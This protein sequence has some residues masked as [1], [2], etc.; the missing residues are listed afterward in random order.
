MAFQDHYSEVL[1]VTSD[2]FCHIF[3]NIKAQLGPEL[4]AIRKQA[5]THPPLP[6]LLSDHFLPRIFSHQKHTFSPAWRRSNCCRSR[7]PWTDL[8]GACVRSTRSRTSCTPT[9]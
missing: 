2:M 8:S 6:S 7:A 4:E 3:D 1:D 9:L 5:R